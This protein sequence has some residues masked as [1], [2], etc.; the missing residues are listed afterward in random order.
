MKETTRIITLEITMI[1]NKEMMAKEDVKK[2]IESFFINIAGTD[3]CNVTS[4]QDFEM[5]VAE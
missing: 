3:D 4:I 1:S 2:S 5:E